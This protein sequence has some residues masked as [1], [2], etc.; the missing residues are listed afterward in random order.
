[1][2]RGNAVEVIAECRTEVPDARRPMPGVAGVGGMVVVIVVMT[3][4]L[5]VLGQVMPGRL[6]IVI[7]IIV[8]IVI[9]VRTGD[10]RVSEVGV[11]GM[12]K[13][14]MVRG[15]EDRA[16]TVDE[17]RHHSGERGAG[18]HSASLWRGVSGRQGN[19]ILR[20]RTDV[21]DCICT[22][23]LLW[24]VYHPSGHTASPHSRP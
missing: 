18:W 7:V 5:L 19:R 15:S 11:V 14:Q 13:R 6:M 22:Y 9:V 21:S 3:L 2:D 4:F 16:A 10:D 8:I 1:M 24:K 20:T 23:V 17:N 12:V